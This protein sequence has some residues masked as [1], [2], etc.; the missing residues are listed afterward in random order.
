VTNTSQRIQA[1]RRLYQL[2]FHEP[3]P[4]GLSIETL[5]G[6]EGVR[7]KA[8]Y[9]NLA[10]K[11]G[12]PKF[13]RTYD[14]HD[15]ENAT[16]INQ[17]LSTA[18][19]CLYATVLTALHALRMSP[20]LGII[21]TGHPRAFAHDIADIYKHEV[22]IPLAF[23]LA[24]HD[25]PGQEARKRLARDLRLLKL[26]PRIVRDINYVVTGI[27]EEPPPRDTTVENLWTPT[28]DTP[29]GIQH[30]NR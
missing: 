2:R 1:A 29:A 20:G 30:D 7:M 27:R 23:A 28:G 6:M 8:I 12:I 18:N 17:A 25:H 21:H 24:N 5:R 15:Y 11:N 4:D 22:T 16:P 26:A 3:L 14:P 9:K 10:Q 13:K 19:A